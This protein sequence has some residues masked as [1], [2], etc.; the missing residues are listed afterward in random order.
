MDYIYDYM[1]HLLNEYAKLLKFE[2]RVPEGAVEL[3]PETMACNRSR[4]P[5]KEF[6]SESMVREPSKKDPCSLPPPFEPSSLRIFYA[7]KQNLINRVE[8]WENEYWKNNQ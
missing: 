4:W 3:C 8:R 2:P 6:M 1:F 7:T 5:E